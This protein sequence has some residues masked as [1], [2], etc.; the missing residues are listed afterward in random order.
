MRVGVLVT[1]DIAVRAAHSLSAHDTVDEVVVIGPA[2]SRSFRVV[3]SAEECD[4][5]VGTGPGAVDKARR[6]NVPLV[7][8]GDHDASGVAVYGANPRGLTLAVASR[9]T[10]PRLV[11]VAHP[12]LTGGGDQR[13]RFPDPLGRLDVLDG[14]YGNRVLA[15]AKSE[16]G[17]AACLVVS[18]GRRVTIVDD[19]RFMSGIAL[20]AGVDVA[21]G[22]QKAVWDEALTYLHTATAMG[23]VMA[24]DS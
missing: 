3:N 7:W 19:A 12:D 24:E 8:D 20:A 14:S 15:Q 17:F 22:A 6:H 10:D 1:G 21:G 16:N 2:K 23:L 5:L 9:E 11:A 18:T 4:V 13:A